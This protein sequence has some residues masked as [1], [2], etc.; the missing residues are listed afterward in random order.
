[1]ANAQGHIVRILQIFEVS[2]R[3]GDNRARAE[4]VARLA[5]KIEAGADFAE[6]LRRLYHVA[7]MQTFALRLMWYA[8]RLS[9]ISDVSTAEHIDDYEI[10][11]LARALAEVPGFAG[12][13]A[14]QGSGPRPRDLGST[15]SHFCSSVAV[16]RREAFRDEEFTGARLATMQA[17]ALAT[18][19]LRAAAVAEQNGDVEDFSRAF[20]GFLDFV[21]A[22]SLLGDVRVVNL[23]E[24]ASLTLQTATETL[25]ADDY[26]ALHQTTLLLEHPVT[27]LE[28]HRSREEGI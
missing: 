26:D 16:L 17:L 8:E 23:I 6:T 12:P 27:L 22:Q 7:G 18:E 13:E 15:V 11:Q 5:E 4:F 3:T 28:Q 1:M 24:N 21:M 10:E 14:E 2:L 25:G 19:R 9:E 20:G